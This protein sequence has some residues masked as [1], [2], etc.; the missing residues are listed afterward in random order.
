MTEPV[1]TAQP[2]RKLRL[3]AKGRHAQHMWPRSSAAAS[4]AF[5]V[6]LMF[7]AAFVAGGMRVFDWERVSASEL[8][9][10]IALGFGLFMTATLLVVMYRAARRGMR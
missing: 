2:T 6:I 8:A 4:A 9:I 5:V 7:T 3:P 1:H 10:D